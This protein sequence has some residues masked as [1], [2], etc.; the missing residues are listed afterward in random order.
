MIID[1]NLTDDDID[2]LNAYTDKSKAKSTK[3]I[4]L[5]FRPHFVGNPGGIENGIQGIRARVNVHKKE[6]PNKHFDINPIFPIDLIEVGQL[7]LW[8]S[9]EGFAALLTGFVRALRPEVVLEVGTNYGRTAKAIAEGLVANGTGHLWTLDMVNFG[10]HE[11]GALNEQEKTCV[12][13]LIGKTPDCYAEMNHIQD[14]EL[15]F[16]D[17]GHTEK[18]VLEDLEFV[19]TH[20]AATCIVLIDNARDSQW[21]EIQE[22]FKSYNAHS[23]LLLNTMCGCQMLQL[24]DQ[25]DSKSNGSVL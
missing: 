12:T 21:P 1:E 9:D 3:S 7:K 24:T 22:M 13:Q 11:T 5:E 15:A 25:G 20:R 6:H 19:N 8:G 4:R 17:G 2:K 10:I 14:I 23:N 16:L 18:E